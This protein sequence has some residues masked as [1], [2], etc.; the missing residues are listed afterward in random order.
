MIINY[1]PDAIDELINTARFYESNQVNLGHR[2][3]DAV[4][5]SLV[6][7]RKN[8]LIWPSDK[9]G[10]RKCIIRKFPYLLIYKLSDKFIYILVLAH[11]SRKPNYWK[12]RD[13]QKR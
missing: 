3:L 5:I 11:T 6:S 12:L 2:F 9:K 7:I 8:P 13:S 10:R 4:D 1:H